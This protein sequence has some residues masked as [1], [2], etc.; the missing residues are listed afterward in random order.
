M[1][2]IF[3]A[4]AAATF[5]LFLGST[6]FGQ[7]FTINF[8]D[9]TKWTAGSGA[10]TSYQTD[11]NYSDQNWSFTGGPSLR[12]GTGLQDGVA[13][14][15]GTYSWR[16][17]DAAGTQWIGTYNN[18]GD[19][20]SFGFDVRRWDNSPDPNYTVEYTINGGTSWNNTGITINNTYLSNSS[21]WTTF[22]YTLPAITSVTSGNFRV[23]V[24]RTAGERIIID[25]FQWTEVSVS[26]TITT[27]S[28]SS[29]SYTVNCSTGAAGTVDFTS[30]GTFNAGNDFVAELSDA[31]GSFAA[32]TQIGTLTLSGASP[33]GT[34]S[35]TIPA[36]TIS[37]SAYRIRVVSTNPAVLGSDNGS[38]ITITLSGGPCIVEPPHMT[39]IIINSCNTTCGEGDNEIIFGSTGDYSV[40]MNSTNFQLSYSSTNPPTTTYTDGLVTN[41]TTTSDLNTAASC[42]GLF[43][44]GTNATLPP[45]STFMLVSNNLCPYDAL[46]FTGL[47]GSGP[48][49]VLYTTDPSWNSSGNFVNN[50]GCGGL[51]YVQ[52][53]ITAT[54]GTVS[55]LDYNFDCSQYSGT[56]G[57]YAKWNYTAG[58]PIEYGNNGCTIDPVVLPVELL[59]MTATPVKNDVEISWTTASERNNNYFVLSHSTDGYNFEVINSIPGAGNSINTLYYQT[60]HIYP[61]NGLNY[62]RLESVD[63]DGTIHFK[64]IRA[65]EIST[66]HAFYD[67]QNQQIILPSKDDYQ[68]LS[69]EGKIVRT[70]S[71]TNTLSFEGRGIYI[72]R[73]LQTG[74]SQKLYI[75]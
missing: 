59:E 66:Q 27:T 30:T 40:L 53:T 4:F 60:V 48:I 7:T 2:N 15:L 6:S 51:R 58:A 34:I 8:D 38:N 57:D 43:V 33:S 67:T 25:N 49:Y 5:L 62:Y 9:D 21:N 65:V 74:V 19:I 69:M 44:D 64:G 22:S 36:G 72:I 14:A 37:G 12:E 75:H 52:T 46:D 24:T 23:R 54:D 17:R 29:L 50:P 70:S 11:H 10:I 63:Y 26:N 35:F 61:E 3:K 55:T 39:S 68:I 31:T 45:N 56:D 47:C 16:L 71:N 1:L 20:Q 41:P 73:N 42:P 32:P 28:V 13:G 18:A